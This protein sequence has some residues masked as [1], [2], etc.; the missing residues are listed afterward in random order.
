MSILAVREML[1]KV[2][3]QPFIIRLADGRSLGVPHPDFITVTG[4]GRTAIVS[5]QVEQSDS[6]VDLLLVTQ[7]KIG[8]S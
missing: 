2:P 4:E 6:S 1:G 8:I 7:L 3:F 5:S